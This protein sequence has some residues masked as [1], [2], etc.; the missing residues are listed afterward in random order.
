MIGLHVIGIVGMV[1]KKRADCLP[2]K[3]E[4][5]FCELLTLHS[6]LLMADVS[7]VDLC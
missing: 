5:G 4:P 6:Y 1:K 2:L 7:F 3:N